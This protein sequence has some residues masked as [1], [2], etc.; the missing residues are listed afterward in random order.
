MAVEPQAGAASAVDEV[1]P[2]AA[3]RGDGA[4]QAEAGRGRRILVQVIVWLTTLL[5]VVA[6]FA[7]WANRQLLNPNN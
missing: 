6:I 7:V 3:G 1:P 5:A 2:P 4:S